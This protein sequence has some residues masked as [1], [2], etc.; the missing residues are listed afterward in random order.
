MPTAGPKS[1]REIEC[2]AVFYLYKGKNETQ[3]ECTALSSLWETA[4]TLLSFIR[5]K[6]ALNT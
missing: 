4:L 6:N 1:D 5:V 2:I 3:L